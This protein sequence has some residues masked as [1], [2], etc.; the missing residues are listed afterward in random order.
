MRNTR[1]SQFEHESL[2]SISY[3]LAMIYFFEWLNIWSLY[4]LRKSVRKNKI[5]RLCGK[6]GSRSVKFI[7]KFLGLDCARTWT[8]DNFSQINWLK[9]EM[10]IWTTSS[11]GE[12][13]PRNAVF[14]FIPNLLEKVMAGVC[15]TGIYLRRD[16]HDGWVLDSR[17]SLRFLICI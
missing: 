1:Y 10:Y 14:E 8:N 2:L 12:E 11:G 6:M 7:R 17:L 4:Q 9:V 15:P 3:N 16:G 13:H 5:W